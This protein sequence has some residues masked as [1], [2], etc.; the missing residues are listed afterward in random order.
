MWVLGNK[1][2]LSGRASSAVNSWPISPAPFKYP[3]LKFLV[4]FYCDQ[5]NKQARFPCP[6]CLFVCLK[7]FIGTG[8]VAQQLTALAV[9]LRDP[10]SGPVSTTWLTTMMPV[11][12]DP[13]LSS[14]VHDHCM[15]TVHRH[16]GR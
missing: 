4:K 11:P 3:S 8:E 7:C 10:G 6:V 9:P 1:L 12:G 15:Y 2:E 13:M 5:T 16:I 14:D